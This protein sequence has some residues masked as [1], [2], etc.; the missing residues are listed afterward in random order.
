MQ[1]RLATQ[2]GTSAPSAA[3]RACQSRQA[4]RPLHQAEHRPGIGRTTAQPGRDRQALFQRDGPAR[5]RGRPSAPGHDI[6]KRI[7]QFPA[8]FAHHAQASCAAGPTASSSP[9]STKAK[10]VSSS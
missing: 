4:L 1:A 6:A 5:L 2:A 7:G 10:A 9:A 8:E 3:A